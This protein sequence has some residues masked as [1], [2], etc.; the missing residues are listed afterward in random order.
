M[1]A[2]E[3][4]RGTFGGPNWA[5]LKPARGPEGTPRPDLGASPTSHKSGAEAS[6]PST[7]DGSGPETGFAPVQ[8]TRGRFYSV[9]AS[10]LRPHGLRQAQAAGHGAALGQEPRLA[11]SLSLGQEV[12][13]G[14]PP[15]SGS[16]ARSVSLTMGEW[17]I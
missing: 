9:S 7:S 17:H 8:V 16:P 3:R 12:Q 10:L 5:S 13:T 1:P 15:R 4:G 6:T 11:H 14:V 2:G